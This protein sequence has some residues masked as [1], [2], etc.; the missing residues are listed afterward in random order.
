M[1][2]L[3][4]NG[5]KQ[6]PNARRSKLALAIALSLGASIV[7]PTALAQDNNSDKYESITVT[8]QKISRTLQETPASI[9]VFSTD[10]LQ[11]KNLG[12]VSEVLFEAANIHGNANGGF[13]I[14][15]VDAFNVSGAGNSALAT[16]YIDGA[17]MPER[18]TRN[19]FSTWDASQIEVLRG[20]QSTL[21]GRN[22]LAG[23][24]IVTTQ[25]PTH[26]WQSKFRVQAGQH[27]EQELAVAFGGGLIEDQLAFRF[28]AEHQDFDGF[29]YNVTRNEHADTRE[30][31]LYR[32]KFLLTPSALSDF[33]AQLSLTRVT[34]SA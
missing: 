22:A 2:K 17:A 6:I 1:N 28:S 18:M 19:G 26:D 27:G 25:A 21:Q 10:A 32:L 11:E 3:A 30:D 20:P 14:R 8:G 5:V 13:N 34:T 33:S 12:T 16:V 23:A 31:R 4:A 15:G 24:V 29:N 9:A 7:A